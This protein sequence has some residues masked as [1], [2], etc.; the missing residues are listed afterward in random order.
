MLFIFCSCKGQA[1]RISSRLYIKRTA[2]SPTTIE[3]AA[4]PTPEPAPSKE[5]PQ[6]S[7]SKAAIRMRNYRERMKANGTYEAYNEKEKKN[8]QKRTSLATKEE[9]EEKKMKG[10]VRVQ[11]WRQKM[12]E[13]EALTRT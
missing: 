1:L 7:V 11:N 9:K 6:A 5:I 4:E 13:T 2:T 8:R 12:M 10:R 3:H